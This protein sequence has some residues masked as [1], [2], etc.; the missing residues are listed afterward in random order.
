MPGFAKSRFL[1]ID[2]NGEY[3]QAFDDSK[4]VYRLSTRVD[5]GDSI[6]IHQSFLEDVEL[7]SIICEA[8]EKTQKPFLSKS[9]DLYRRLRG[10]D[11]L[12]A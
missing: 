9:I 11:N 6:P 5:T 10:T 3:T 2:F 12:M 4:R 8:T 7:W 1:L